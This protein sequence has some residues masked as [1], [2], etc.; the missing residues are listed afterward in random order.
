MNKKFSLS[1]SVDRIVGTAVAVALNLMMV[2]LIFLLSKD[3]LSL[4]IVTVCV[5]LVAAVL[6][7]YVLNLYNAACTPLPEN[8]KI[9]VHGFPD[10]TYDL[11]DAAS[12]QT[13]SYKSGALA[14]R[15]IVF[16]NSADDVVASVPTF[17]FSR[18]GVMAEPLAKNIAEALGLT[19]IPS[20]PVW[21]YDKELRKKHEKEVAAKEKESRKAEF[22]A[23]KNKLLR[24]TK[25][26]SPTPAAPEE[27]RDI[28]DVFVAADD[29]INYDALD[30]EK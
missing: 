16:C 25:A 1:S 6:I 8:R 3:T 26:G 14:T 17:F 21:E 18:Q 11:S 2:F 28:P 30:D 24:R 13:V 29:G 19:F 15:T 20:L 5:V 4:I 22:Q 9:L 7:F 10:C 23:L 12:V 27:E